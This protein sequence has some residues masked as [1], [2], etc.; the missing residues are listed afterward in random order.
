MERL[1]SRILNLN[2]YY[3]VEDEFEQIKDPKEREIRLL[4]LE[5]IMEAAMDLDVHIAEYMYEQ[6][7]RELE[8]RGVFFVEET[9]DPVVNDWDIMFDSLVSKEIKENTKDYSDQ[10]RWHL[11]SFELLTGLSG[12][13]AK[14]RF[15]EID[16]N[17]L[18]LFYDY[19]DHCYHVTGAEHLT[20]QD[21]DELQEYGTFDRA[22]KYF[23]DR[24][25][26]WCYIVTHETV[27][28]G[29]YFY[30]IDK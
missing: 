5:K 22:D 24:K 2:E 18:K 3:T 12:E 15:D 13:E 19:D 1:E 4:L 21:I 17:E 8:Q 23:F 25:A 16:K 28:C 30:Q 6:K 27:H 11:F 29:P 20:T 7:I 26:K 9:R 14:K 10:F